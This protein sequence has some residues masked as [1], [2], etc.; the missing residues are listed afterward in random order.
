MDAL[1]GASL[2]ALEMDALAAALYRSPMPRA[3]ETLE[4]PP[5]LATGANR[6][7]FMKPFFMFE[8]LRLPELVAVD[9]AVIVAM[10]GIA[11]FSLPPAEVA[12]TRLEA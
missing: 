7:F 12:S 10:D 1:A 9:E 3:L 11:I 4:A 8:G 6:G 2:K 5:P